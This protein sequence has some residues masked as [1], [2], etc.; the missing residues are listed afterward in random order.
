MEDYAEKLLIELYP[1]E[2]SNDNDIYVPNL[3]LSNRVINCL[4]RS[5][6]TSLHKLLHIRVR[7]LDTMKNLGSKSAKEVHDFLKDFSNSNLEVRRLNNTQFCDFVKA[8]INN[9]ISLDETFI[10]S[11][12]EETRKL[13]EPYYETVDCIGE[14]LSKY[15]FENP[16]YM[17]S[18]I[19]A[20]NL[21]SYNIESY[22]KRKEA[23]ES[24]LSEIPV[25]RLKMKVQGFINAY[26]RDEEKQAKLTSFFGAD[27]NC[28]AKLKDVNY[29]KIYESD[30]NFVTVSNFFKWCSFDIKNEVNELFEKM[31]AKENV[32]LVIKERTAG[33]T[34]NQIGNILNIS[35]ERVRQL[36]TRGKRIFE[37]WQNKKRILSKISA[38]RD[39][40]KVLSSSELLEYFEEH[41]NEMTYLLQT[42]INS[43][44]VYDSQLDVFVL[45]DE[46]ISAAVADYIESFPTDFSEKQ[47]DEYLLEL[48][49]RDIPLEL[50]EKAFFEVYK[51][52]GSTYHRINQKLCDVYRCILEKYFSDGFRIYIPEEMLLFRRIAVEEYGCTNLPE[53]DRAIYTRI[54]DIAIMCDRGKYK[55]KSKTYISKELER[56]IHDYIVNS[57]ATIFLTNVLF[58]IFEEELMVFGID[59]K[60]Y[61]QG[62]LKEL[63]GNEF[64]FKR[65]YVSKDDKVTSLYSEIVQF[66]KKYDYPITKA[67]VFN[68]FPGL[69]DIVFQIAITD[70]NVLNLYGKY[71]HASQL[72]VY[73]TDIEYFRD[74]I[75]MFLGKN[76]VCHYGDI[77]DYIERHNSDLLKRLYVTFPT[78]LF[79]VLE[80]LF[81]KEYQF[82]RPFIAK[83]NVEIGDPELQLK[84]IIVGRELISFAEITDFMKE[85]RI[86]VYSYL[87][88]YNEFSKTHLIMDS[89]ML[90]SIEYIGIDENIANIVVSVL[91]KEVNDTTPIRNLK[92]I[93]SF[94]KLNVPWSDWLI[95]SVVR[96]WSVNLEVGVS[97]SMFKYAVPLVSIKGQM[98]STNFSN[99]ENNNHVTYVIDDL[100]NIDEL[101]ED[102]IELEEDE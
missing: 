7:D 28:D 71:L 17:V 102:L 18:I 89:E 57:P 63:F 80:Y 59:N 95:Y 60:Y 8:N 47:Y 74:V 48:V 98:D 19:K 75:E 11:L 84:E 51:K 46:S 15:C 40:D 97:N 27:S 85:N 14:E 88:Y 90:A 83:H 58:S 13:I 76:S 34:L 10:N 55:P 31:Y 39:M 50:F 100:D 78:S 82:K 24:L 101:I 4:M 25:E 16:M 73:D 87:D 69:T 53:N 37:V 86:S 91:E 38:I 43:S 9:I 64:F 54:Q 70:N 2:L 29:E 94:P 66:I 81:V 52:D 62:V 3:P 42:Y 32:K 79:S 67:D 68:A 1:I 33:K 49:E 44:Y 12:D 72:K 21:F 77:Y 65:D 61:L 99:I 20:F 26:T 5:G 36:E 93:Y 56:K 92:C 23:I 6:I 45:G 22:T 35:R 41:Y 96:K 30:S